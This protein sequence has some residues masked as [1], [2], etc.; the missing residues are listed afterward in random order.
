M[1]KGSRFLSLILRHDPASAN[2]VLD[3]AGWTDV[4]ILLKNLGIEMSALESIVADNNKQ[5]FSFNDSKTKIRANQGHSVKVDLELKP[6]QPPYELYHGTST[7]YLASIYHHG[8]DKKKRHHVHLSEDVETAISV[9]TRH[10]NPIVL[11]ID[12]F[13]MDC[14]GILFY[15]SANGVWLTEYIDPKYLKGKAS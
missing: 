13:Q 9:G 15:R 3:S 10:G 5:R 12:S 6:I 1:S 11:K 4:K 8:I 14:D 7:R 2:I